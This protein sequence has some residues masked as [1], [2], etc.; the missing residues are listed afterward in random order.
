MIT[1]PDRL[2]EVIASLERGE[3][4]DWKKIHDLQALDLARAGEQFARDAVASDTASDELLKQIVEA[5]LSR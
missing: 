3:P 4:V 2:S 1:L 5:E